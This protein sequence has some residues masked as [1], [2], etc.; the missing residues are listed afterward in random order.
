MTSNSLLD[1]YNLLF[2]VEVTVF[3][4][5]SA[6]IMVFLQIVHGFY[7]FRNTKELIRDP[8]L[9]LF[10]VFGVSSIAMSIGASFLLSLDA[11]NF[12]PAFDFESRQLFQSNF[13]SLVVLLLAS[14]STLSFVVLILRHLA[15]LQPSRALFILTRRISNRQIQ[16][17]LWAKDPPQ[18]PA[19]VRVKIDEESPALIRV[20]KD[21][22]KA[23][24]K[25]IK[26][27]SNSTRFSEDPFIAFES[28]LI[29]FIKLSDLASITE[30]MDHLLVVSTRFL[31]SLPQKELAKWKPEDSLARSLVAHLVSLSS[32]VLEVA[33][34]EG[35]S[36]LRSPMIAYSRRLA[37]FLLERDYYSEFRL[38]SDFWKSTAAA[39]VGINKKEFVEIVGIYQLAAIRL[40]TKETREEDSSIEHETLNELFRS[41]GWL[42]E[43]LII[44]NPGTEEPIMPNNVH[45]A[46]LD[47]ILEFLLEVA[48]Q[49]CR[50][51]RQDYPLIFFD[52][53]EVIINR[54][55]SVYATNPNSK[56]KEY[57]TRLAVEFYSFADSAVK[58]GNFDGTALAAM[59]IWN[60]YKK[61]AGN[62]LEDL[63]NEILG[64]FVKVG[65]LAAGYKYLGEQ[66]SFLGTVDE[67]IAS[68]LVELGKNIDSEILESYIRSH[69]PGINRYEVWNF[70]TNLGIR[71]DTNFGLMFDQATGETY[72]DED[73]RRR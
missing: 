2:S 58:V 55:V 49:Y 47:S 19:N 52:A 34:A 70:I 41:V 43:Y 26:E 5:A 22:N 1:F 31:N 66:K 42:G 50:Q 27:I 15:Y 6:A 61:L 18:L 38:F 33:R 44:T 57:V 25:R 36:W 72:S 48:D 63:S 21:E 32:N 68:K 24:G 16:S 56:T 13:Y 40:L 10:A 4:A 20:W 60:L 67:W 8:F 35:A 53:L 37:F 62:K 46:E 30:A 3:G 12:V 7:S 51:R 11:H 71:M 17:F 69:D 14:L 64:Q 28:M 23:Y 39:S 59:S 73:P 29:R 45:V 9:I 65:I 54:L